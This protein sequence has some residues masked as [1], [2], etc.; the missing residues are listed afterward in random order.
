M[1]PDSVMNLGEQALQVTVLLSAPI[2]LSALAI[3]FIVAMFQ[4]ATQINEQTLSFVP[5]LLITVVVLSIAG[6]WMLRLI[7]NFT[8]QT[9]LSI[10]DLIG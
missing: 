8:R 2:L 6:P 3:G 4:A 9:Y 1:T 7:I 5:K 10:P